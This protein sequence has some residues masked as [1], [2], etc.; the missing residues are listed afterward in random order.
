[1]FLLNTAE[2]TVA[3]F[4]EI[5]LKQAAV[6]VADCDSYEDAAVRLGLAA[7]EVKHRIGELEAKLCL[8]VFSPGSDPPVLTDE[9]KFLVQGFRE[10]LARHEQG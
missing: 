5:A 6:A 1:M 4:I 8:S 3:E 10:A 9:G 2:V 7:S